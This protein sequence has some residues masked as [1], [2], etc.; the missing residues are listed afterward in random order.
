MQ[1]K[2]IWQRILWILNRVRR[3]AHRAESVIAQRLEAILAGIERLGEFE[4]T[5]AAIVLLFLAMLSDLMFGLHP[6]YK[7]ILY[8]PLWFGAWFIGRRPA[9]LLAVAASIWICIAPIVDGQ[10]YSSGMTTGTVVAI[11][12]FNFGTWVIGRLHSVYAREKQRARID[13]LTGCLNTRGFYEA[14]E[15]ALDSIREQFRPF[16]LFYVD[17]D[18]FKQLN[19]TVGHLEAD[20]AL[21][22]LGRSL[23]SQTRTEDLVARVG[24]DEFVVVLAGIGADMAFAA[25]DRLQR[26]IQLD[27]VRKG[28]DISLSVGCLAFNEAPESVQSAVQMADQIMYAA[29]RSGKAKVVQGIWP[30]KTIVESARVS[31]V[32]AK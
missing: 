9:A 21:K 26:K 3:S 32:Y 16:A 31:V 19:D 13:A 8:L 20:K 6:A 27:L 23:K 1:T 25:A 22:L 24:G 10:K 11:I 5:A 7:H 4:K 29:K 30:P 17:L 2:D 12:M 15:S 18:N 28:F 14:A